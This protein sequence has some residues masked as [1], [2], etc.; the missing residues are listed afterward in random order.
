MGINAASV[1][2]IAENAGFSKGGFYSNFRSK[3]EIF[4]ALLEEHMNGE[5]AELSRLI[6]ES[7]SVDDF[8]SQIDKLYKHLFDDPTMCVLS[9]EFQLLAMRN[10]IVRKHYQEL[11]AHHR[12]VLIKLLQNAMIR[13]R[14]S[15][16]SDP[17][18]VIDMLTALA[19]G[20]VLQNAAGATLG[21]KTDI[22]GAMVQYLR[23]M[24][25]SD[26]KI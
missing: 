7:V 11:S 10:E 1:D 13:F 9:V 17:A 3:E 12:T 4:L 19:H 5:V 20:L 14:S 24:I 18:D 22:S 2:V 16:R 25:Q 23:M 26:Q 21:E 15:L 8:L 6:S